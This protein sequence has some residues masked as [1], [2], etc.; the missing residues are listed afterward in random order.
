MSDAADKVE[1]DAWKQIDALRAE[2]DE[3]IAT[4]LM[5][6]AS[7]HVS[8]GRLDEAE[9]L[10]EQVFDLQEA[11]HGSDHPKVA[12]VLSNLGIIEHYRGRAEE[13]ARLWREALVIYETEYGPTHLRVAQ[14]LSNLLGNVLASHRK[15]PRHVV[16]H[17]DFTPNRAR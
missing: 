3:R 2:V 12:D 7:V 17:A 6:L 15:H 10:Y 5:N 9:R 11:R 8:Y 13:A 16:H 14:I 1:R 4:S